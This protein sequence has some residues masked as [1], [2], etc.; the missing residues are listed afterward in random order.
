[1]TTQNLAFNRPL[2]PERNMQLFQP[3]KQTEWVWRKEG[4]SCLRSYEDPKSATNGLRCWYFD[5]SKFYTLNL[6]LRVDNL[7]L[8][9]KDFLYVIPK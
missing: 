6:Y 5:P 4:L 2:T 1:M 7:P 3:P 9:F 8:F